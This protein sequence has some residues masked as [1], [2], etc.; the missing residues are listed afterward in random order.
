VQSLS[1]PLSK[2]S[3]AALCRAGFF[4]SSLD[5]D[6]PSGETVHAC[7]YGSAE[8]KAAAARAGRKATRHGAKSEACG[9]E[10]QE[11]G[12]LAHIVRQTGWACSKPEIR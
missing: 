3:H 6:F 10:K 4:S 11:R 5:A 9:V 12:F 8:Q 7:V 2:K 1:N